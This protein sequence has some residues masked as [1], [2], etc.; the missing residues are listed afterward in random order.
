MTKTYFP[1]DSGSGANVIEDQWSKMARLFCPT[2]VVKGKLNQLEPFADNSGLNTK[3]KSGQAFLEGFFFESDAEETLSI[4]TAHPTLARIDRVIV[5][6]DRTNNLIDLAVLTGTP[7]ASPTVPALTQSSTTWEIPLARVAVAAGDTAIAA[8]D[9]TDER[10][11]TVDWTS[12][13]IPEVILKTADENIKNTTIQD[14]D[15]LKFN[16]QAQEVRFFDV[17]LIVNATNGTPDF[18]CTWTVPAGVTMQWGLAAGNEAVSGFTA[19]GLAATAQAVGTLSESGT[20]SV[21]LGNFSGDN[22][23]HIAGWIIVGSNSGLVQFRWAENASEASV[24]VT[25]KQ[26]SF[27]KHYKIYG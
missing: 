26:Y 11:Y 3:V 9:V 1:F 23:I 21:G 6:L 25:V 5:R 19:I 8:G 17:Y 20:L 16:V 24:G 18:K 2:G 13:A 14:D 22:L 7:N 4:A 10:G 15:H 27:L 12:P